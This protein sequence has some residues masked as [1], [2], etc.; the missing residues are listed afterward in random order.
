VWDGDLQRWTAPFV[1][2]AIN[3]RIVHR[4]NQLLGYA[5]GTEF[6]YGESM[7]M[8]QG[9]KGRLAAHGF[10][11]GYALFTGLMAVGPLRNLLAAT[12]LPKPG[13]GPSQEV[14]DAGYFRMK[15]VGKGRDGAGNPFSLT[16][17][18]R[19]VGDPGYNE[20]A[21]MLSQSAL[22]LLQDREIAQRGGI[23]TPA[24]ALGHPLL[25]RLRQ[26]K[27]TFEIGDR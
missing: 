20:T 9:M 12:L 23:L 13:E 1:M 2:A 5:Y 17:E 26:E 16:G 25:H 22:C 10:S 3:T 27:M 18:I 4:T 8:G 15:L 19:G 6:R 14:R 7:S 24:A 11:G 21:K